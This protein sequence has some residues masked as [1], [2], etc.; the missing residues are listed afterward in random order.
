MRMTSI[1]DAGVNG[2]FAAFAALVVWLE[3][4]GCVLC[5]GVEMVESVELDAVDE[6]EVLDGLSVSESESVDVAAAC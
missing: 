5:V 4:E 6:T 2:L 3:V 1:L